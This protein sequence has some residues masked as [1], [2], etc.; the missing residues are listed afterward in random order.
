MKSMK[1]RLVIVCVTLITLF[2]VSGCTTTE[3]EGLIEPV[4]YSVS[5]EIVIH[6]L[7]IFRN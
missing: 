2:T 3:R 7:D 1:N 4:P 6:T 5:K